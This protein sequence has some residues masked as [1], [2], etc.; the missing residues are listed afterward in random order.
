MRRSR[1][2]K[3]DPVLAVTSITR[4]GDATYANRARRSA[5][6]GDLVAGDVDVGSMARG[7]YCLLA[8]SLPSGLGNR[9][10]VGSTLG[11]KGGCAAGGTRVAQCAGRHAGRA[12]GA[13]GALIE[14]NGGRGRARRRGDAGRRL[15][16]R[17]A[18]RDARW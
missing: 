10:L 14:R 5:G 18:P 17:S 9:T 16:A 3:M 12:A 2:S 7:Q 4:A 6:V 1:A 15:F 13:A 11:G 8:R